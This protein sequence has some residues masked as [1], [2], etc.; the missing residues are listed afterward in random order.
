M[1]PTRRK[2]WSPGTHLVDVHATVQHVAWLFLVAIFCLKL[3]WTLNLNYYSSVHLLTLIFWFHCYFFPQFLM[4]PASFVNW[5]LLSD[6]GFHSLVSRLL[7]SGQVCVCVCLCCLMSFVNITFNIFSL[8]MWTQMWEKE[9]GLK[10]RVLAQ[11]YC[12]MRTWMLYL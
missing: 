10:G 8:K 7:V 3:N 5:Q 6:I 9:S 4:P 12:S 11:S 1:P 2:K